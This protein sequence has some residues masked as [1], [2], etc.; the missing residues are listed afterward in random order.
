MR[1]PLDIAR[2]ESV[3]PVL[4]WIGTERARALLQSLTRGVPEAGLTRSAKA[5]LKRLDRRK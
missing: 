5:A 4:E 1:P 2:A 3:V